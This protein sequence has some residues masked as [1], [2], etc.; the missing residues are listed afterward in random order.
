MGKLFCDTSDLRSP[1][2]VGLRKQ[3]GLSGAYVLHALKLMMWDSETKCVGDSVEDI[4][5]ALDCEVS[6]V[7]ATILA[8][9][10]RGL[11]TETDLGLSAPDVID[12]AEGLKKRT[13]GLKQNSRYVHR[14]D[15]VTVAVS[16]PLQ[17]KIRQDKT[18][19][20][21]TGQ[22]PEGGCG[23]KPPELE[24]P[25]PETPPKQ[26]PERTPEPPPHPDLP[27]DDDLDPWKTPEERAEIEGYLVPPDDPDIQQQPA[28]VNAGRRPM[29]K[30][31][32]LWFNPL[33]LRDAI[34]ELIGKGVAE[35]DVQSVFRRAAVHVRGKVATGG[36][37]SRFDA[38]GTVTGWA[39]RET[40][41]TA[42]AIADKARSDLY[43]TRAR[44]T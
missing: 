15:T 13:S 44:G 35:S 27:T 20:D 2:M 28:F 12:Q 30:H 6:L 4:A 3:V 16:A 8:A 7:K 19:S 36:H 18:R 26:P 5:A 25:P 41:G 29:R 37:P 23:G 10:K 17:D 21:Q 11:L 32:E 22:D 31:P 38:F 33:E 34:A 40:L 39:L 1:S 42:K 43:L 24:P 9:L 14:H